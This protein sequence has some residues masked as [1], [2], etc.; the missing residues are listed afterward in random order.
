VDPVPDSLLLRKSGPSTFRKIPGRLLNLKFYYRLP[1]NYT[2]STE[3]GP[4][5]NENVG[6]RDISPSS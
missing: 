1:K 4:I 2:P 6:D 5:N 3:R